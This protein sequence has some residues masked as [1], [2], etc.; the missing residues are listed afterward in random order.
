MVNKPKRAAR[1]ERS[2]MTASEKVALI[3][4][5]RGHDHRFLTVEGV[6]HFFEPFGLDAKEWCYFHRADPMELKGLTMDDG[7]KGGTGLAAEEIAEAI[8]RH[9]NTGFT[10]WQ[11]GRGYRLRSACDA[12]EAFLLK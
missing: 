1:R 9:L 2:P 8:N 3:K 7:S 6:Q 5:L 11:M 12:I 4:D 10:P